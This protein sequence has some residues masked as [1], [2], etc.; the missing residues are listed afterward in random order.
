[1]NIN[2]DI[3]KNFYQV[4]TPCECGD[5]QYFII[6]IEE[7]QPLICEYLKSLN[8]NPHKPYELQ[9]IILEEEKRI[10]YID[11]VYL[12]FG[13]IEHNQE[14]LINNIKVSITKETIYPIEKMNDEYFIVSFGPISM[15]YQKMCDKY[16]TY[17]EKLSIIKK[18]VD[19]YDPIGL[20]QL[21][22]PE[23]EYLPEVKLI[24]ERVKKNQINWKDIQKIFK[25]QFEENVPKEICSKIATNIKM[26]L[27]MKSY[28]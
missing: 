11:C 23:D 21:G 7:V 26:H 20:L 25:S 16:L 14:M 12:V 27:N 28:E 15:S 18:I 1:M 8:I 6:H 22:C 13:S 4:Y 5:C 3:T 2:K 9:S 17:K 19:E 24:T 10:E